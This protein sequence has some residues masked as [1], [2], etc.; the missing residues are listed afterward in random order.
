MAPALSYE[1]QLAVIQAAY[2][3]ANNQRPVDIPALQNLFA[4]GDVEASDK[5]I[6]ECIDSLIAILRKTHLTSGL[7]IC[8]FADFFNW[9]RSTCIRAIS[10]SARSHHVAFN[11]LSSMEP[12]AE[13]INLLVLG[14]TNALPLILP[15][16]HWIWINKL[17]YVMPKTKAALAAQMHYILKEAPGITLASEF[18][19]LIKDRLVE[20][21]NSLAINIKDIGV[22]KYVEINRPLRMALYNSVEQGRFR[23]RLQTMIYLAVMANCALDYF[24]KEDYSS[25]PGPF[26]SQNGATVKMDTYTREI[27]S[28]MLRCKNDELV[29]EMIAR[30]C[31]DKY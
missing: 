8:T 27:L 19:V 26:V 2:K 18:E 16:K 9:Q 6:N 1:Q 5:I 20:H 13:S 25:F 29:N 12:L 22:S 4:Q 3:T 10:D 24:I 23:G 7:N 21:C 14:D 15:N 17:Q 11:A 28:L 30:I 31:T